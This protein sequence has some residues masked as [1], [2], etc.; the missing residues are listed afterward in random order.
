[1]EHSSRAG[2]RRVQS[3]FLWQH[4]GNRS[5]FESPYR[6]VS[7]RAFC[8][9]L[10]FSIFGSYPQ[11]IKSFSRLLRFHP[12]SKRSFTTKQEAQEWEKKFHQQNH[13]DMNMTF[14]AFVEIYTRDL[15]PRLKENTW[16]T[17]EN[18]ISPLFCPISDS[19]K[20]AKLHQKGL[21]FTI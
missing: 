5:I 17:K 8:R 3:G 6:W 18:I 2:G 15:R 9:L 20:S 1:M 14:A 4:S 13:A 16:L 11:G 19:G 7:V 10:A 12:K 21:E